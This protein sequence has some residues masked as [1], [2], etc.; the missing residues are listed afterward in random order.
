MADLGPCL[1]FGAPGSAFDKT[2]PKRPRFRSTDNWIVARGSPMQDLRLA[3]ERWPNKHDLDEV[4]PDNPM[5]VSF[6]AHVIV[7]N[8]GALKSDR[9]CG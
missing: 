9:D 4:A 5:Y 6:G 1:A 7:A 2:G 8:S 3:E